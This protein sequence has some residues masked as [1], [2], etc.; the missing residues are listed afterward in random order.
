MWDALTFMWHQYNEHFSR[1]HIELPTHPQTPRNL[2]NHH[3]TICD[4]PLAD[5]SSLRICI[6]RFSASCH[7]RCKFSLVLV[8]SGSLGVSP[9]G[10]CWAA[11]APHRRVASLRWT[12]P[13]TWHLQ[14]EPQQLQSTTLCDLVQCNTLRPQQDG[15]HFVD[16]SF[17]L[18]LLNENNYFDLNLTKFA[19]NRWRVIINSG[20]GLGPT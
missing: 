3:R 18:I 1:K 7:P 16:D 12:W 17:K 13:S 6:R 8:C 4:G 14:R 15:C 10:A 19:T 9:Y 5:G 20:N 2:M 11:T